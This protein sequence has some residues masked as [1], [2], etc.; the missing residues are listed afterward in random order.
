M[1]DN[2]SSEEFLIVKYGRCRTPLNVPIADVAKARFVECE[3]C[4]SRPQLFF[5]TGLWSFVIRTAGN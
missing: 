4:A 5:A 1:K 2:R 3:G